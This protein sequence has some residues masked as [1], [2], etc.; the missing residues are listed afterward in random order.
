ML[1]EFDFKMFSD[2]ITVCIRDVVKGLEF[3]H[4]IEIAHRDPKPSNILVSN[5]HYAQKEQAII[6]KDY[7]ACPIV[8]KVA[9]FGLSRSLDAQTI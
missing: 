8:C 4:G 1:T 6:E 5:Q 9:D 3:L 7:Q 2:V